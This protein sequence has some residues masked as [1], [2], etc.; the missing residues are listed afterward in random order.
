MKHLNII[1]SKMHDVIGVEWDNK[2][3]TFDYGTHSWD[4]Y[5]ENEFKFWMIRYLRDNKEAREE[6]MRQ[7]VNELDTI[8]GTVGEFIF[9][10]GCKSENK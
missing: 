7:P 6:I 1:L 4:Y 9:N 2:L 8:K 5:K 3:E 10:Y